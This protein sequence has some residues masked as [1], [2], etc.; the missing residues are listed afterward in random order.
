MPNR[1]DCPPSFCSPSLSWPQLQ[2]MWSALR[3]WSSLG[4]SEGVSKGKEER[5]TKEE[6]TEEGRRQSVNVT[7]LRK[8]KR[9]SMLEIRKYTFVCVG[10]YYLISDE[11]EDGQEV[12]FGGY[13]IKTKQ[14]DVWK[15]FCILRS[16]PQ[17]KHEKKQG[18]SLCHGKQWAL[19]PLSS[20]LFHKYTSCL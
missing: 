4:I 8:W 16:S 12:S 13:I 20:P 10:L 2:P 1:G 7:R 11:F 9:K 19:K 3:D 5:M 18:C 15:Y 14:G 17:R 6:G